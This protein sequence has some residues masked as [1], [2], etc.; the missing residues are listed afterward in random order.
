ME[1]GFRPQYAL[2]TAPPAIAPVPAVIAPTPI[3]VVDIGVLAV[4]VAPQ[5]K[6][7]TRTTTQTMPVSRILTMTPEQAQRIYGDEILVDAVSP[8]LIPIEKLKQGQW[9]SPAQAIEAAQTIAI[10]SYVEQITQSAIRQAELLKTR[11][12]T[13][14]AIQ[15]AVQQAIQAQIK[16]IVSP[17]VKTQVVTALQT[18]TA[19]Q[20]IVTTGFWATITPITPITPIIPPPTLKKKKK[21][22]IE[23]GSITWLQGIFWKYIPP[24]WDMD[25]PITLKRGVAPL[26]A[27]NTELLTPQETIQMIGRTTAVVPE[28]ISIDLG[29]VDA[30]ITGGGKDIEFRGKGELTD[31]GERLPIT[32]QGMSVDGA[33]PGAVVYNE[34]VR[35]PLKR[36]KKPKKKPRRRE[37][38]LSDI[39][40]I[41]GEI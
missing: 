23:R 16:T 12:V 35:R 4:L 27:V 28:S 8:L 22:K 11:G 37:N 3:P 10:Q 24:P 19:I 32:T 31:V 25:K 30:F 14:A 36:T 9:L 33:F 18:V 21:K 40:E 15:S 20:P 1:V 41:R 5:I 34:E 26:G 39:L 29:I 6:V 2:V 7:S 38:D 17:A 13:Q